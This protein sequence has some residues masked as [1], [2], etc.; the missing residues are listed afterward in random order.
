MGSQAL[1]I[2]SPSKQMFDCAAT[3]GLRS[4]RVCMPFG[5]KRPFRFGRWMTHTGLLLLHPSHSA[6]AGCV[7]AGAGAAAVGGGAE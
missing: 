1:S 4:L 2:A 3:R 5:G 6:R 7:A